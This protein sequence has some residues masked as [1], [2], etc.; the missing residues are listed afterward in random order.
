MFGNIKT[1]FNFATV[2][3]GTRYKNSSIH[4]HKSGSIERC[5]IYKAHD[6]I[7]VVK[8]FIYTNVVVLLFCW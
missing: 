3:I 2:M 7:S 8:V 6:V 4:I 1:R 5:T